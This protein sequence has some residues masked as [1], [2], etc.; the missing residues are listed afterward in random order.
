MLTMDSLLATTNRT[1]TGCLEW[2]GTRNKGG[3]GTK[4]VGSRADGSRTTKLAHRIVYELVNGGI[5]AKMCVLHKCDN[6]PCI[7]PEHLFVGT[8][9]DNH[10]DML[11]KGRR[12][13]LKGEERFNSKLLSSQVV[14]IKKQ[15]LQ[16]VRQSDIARQ[17]GV[18]QT[19]I[20]AIKTGK[21]WTH[22][23]A[24]IEEVV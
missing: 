8:R 1:P 10:M 23:D 12:K 7:N 9:A 5:D 20:S 2:A 18:N 15:L 4:T 22:I 13:D 19:L 3:Y 17:Y 6:P 14:D 24:H 16:G 11:K 21:I